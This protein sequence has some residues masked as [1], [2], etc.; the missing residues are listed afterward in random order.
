MESPP[1]RGEGG[2]AEV[3]LIRKRKAAGVAE[4]SSHS[5]ATRPGTS[6]LIFSDLSPLSQPKSSHPISVGELGNME[7]DSSHVGDVA[8]PSPSTVGMA[9]NLNKDLEDMDPKVLAERRAKQN[10]RR[11]GIAAPTS[12]VPSTAAPP[13]SSVSKAPE[14]S[15]A[16]TA[17]ALAQVCPQGSLQGEF[18]TQG[19]Y[20]RLCWDD[21]FCP[22]DQVIRCFPSSGV[23]RRPYSPENLGKHFNPLS[24][25]CV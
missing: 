17:L 3:P 4:T 8:R 10:A 20:G 19:V 23:A 22:I 18:S 5:K 24:F 2:S 25:I 9:S 16:Q 11:A 13:S 15:Q 1:S 12:S 7:V 21:C 14:T 6:D